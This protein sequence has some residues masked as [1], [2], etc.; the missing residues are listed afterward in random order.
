MSPSPRR[1]RIIR[2]RKA[3]FLLETTLLLK[4][5]T[6]RK[7][8]FTIVFSIAIIISAFGQTS[9]GFHNPTDTASPNGWANA[10]HAL[11]S[12]DSFTTAKLSSG[13]HCPRFYLS[14]NNG[15]KYSSSEVVLFQTSDR[16]VKAGSPNDLWGHFWSDSEFSNTN[17]RLKIVNP[18]GNISQ[19]YKNFNLSIPQ[20]ASIT[21]IEVQVEGHGDDNPNDRK[22]FVDLIQVNVYYT[23]NTGF[24]EL[25]YISNSISLYPNPATK[26]LNIS[27]RNQSTCKAEVI[28]I[29]GKT[30]IT[31]NLSNNSLNISHLI[32][33]LYFLKLTPNDGSPVV[34]RFVKQ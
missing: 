18:G 14:W 7:Y 33:G 16:V 1:L 29:D 24:V 12:D 34:T 11:A 32:A 2:G 13:C 31:E 19:G 9:T 23:F 21:G 17:F 3:T 26:T 30:L 27:F 6:M 8:S 15:V 28:S 22:E 10:I 4:I 20:R 5:K 25:P